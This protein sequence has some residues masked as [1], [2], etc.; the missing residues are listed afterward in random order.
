MQPMWD[1][2]GRGS[3]I[4]FVHT[5][6]VLVLST[7]AT[8]EPMYEKP[9]PLFLRRDFSDEHPDSY[10]SL[11]AP[12]L[13]VAVG[14]LAAHRIPHGSTRMD[15]Q[16]GRRQSWILLMSVLPT[17]RGKA[18]GDRTVDEWPMLNRPIP[19]LM[20]RAFRLSIENEFHMS[21][22]LYMY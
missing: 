7:V 8:V 18:V 11:F 20:I 1:M 17:A 15:P 4:I 9:R 2:D 6:I 10:F 19:P 14:G 12:W 16:G 3:P 22:S 5:H 21:T 13:S